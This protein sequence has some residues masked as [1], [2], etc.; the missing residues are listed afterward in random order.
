MK[1]NARGLPREEPG[2][3]AN[4]QHPAQ[5][6]E[7][8]LHSTQGMKLQRESNLRPVNTYGFVHDMA[9][10]TLPFTGWR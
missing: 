7:R 3:I 5:A 9:C 6:S 8:R 4:R 10:Q 1:M 2:P